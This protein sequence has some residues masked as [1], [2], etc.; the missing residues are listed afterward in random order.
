MEK[1]DYDVVV[2]SVIETHYTVRGT[3]A[4]D[5]EIKFSKKVHNKEFTIPGV[6]QSGPVVTLKV[7]P[8][9]LLPEGYELEII[10]PEAPGA[11]VFYRVRDKVSGASYKSPII[12]KAIS[13]VNSFLASKTPK[14]PLSS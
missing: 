2:R 9:E 13:K 7:D 14:D 5:A 3:S 6:I 11:P 1:K 12:R 4:F 10:E 8:H